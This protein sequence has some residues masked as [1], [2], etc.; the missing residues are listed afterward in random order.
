MNLL[1]LLCIICVL[2]SGSAF[3]CPSCTRGRLHFISLN[4]VNEADV[5]ALVEKAEDLWAQVEQLRKKSNELSMEAESLGQ[6]AETTTADAM[7]SLKESISEE[8]I[9]E[10]SNAQNL[11]IDLGSLL[12]QAME[13]SKKAD[14]IEAL[15]EEALAASEA[16]LE[17]HLI[18]FPDDDEQ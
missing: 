15:A 17:Q 14:E 2:S 6:E 5:I 13:A 16:A 4:L 11:S 18:D 3:V 7:E 1:R 12:E 9:A 8:K 10:A